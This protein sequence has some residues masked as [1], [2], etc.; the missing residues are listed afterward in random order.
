MKFFFDRNISIHIARMINHF[1]RQNLVVH[2]DEDRRF[3]NNADDILLINTVKQDDDHVIWVTSDISQRTN[4][5]ERQALKDSGMSLVFFK[6]FHKNANAHYQAMKVL[7]VW[8]RLC[9]LCDTNRVKMAYEVPAG[10]FTSQ[11]VDVLG[12]ASSAVWR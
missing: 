10:S 11:K 6:R 5:R 1:D 2:Q 12:P 7:A 8:P 3:V 4:A 9:Q